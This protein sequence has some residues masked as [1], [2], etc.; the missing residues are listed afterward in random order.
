MGGHPAGA[1]SAE[2]V[3]QLCSVVSLMAQLFRG[4]PLRQAYLSIVFSGRAYYPVVLAH[5]LYSPFEPPC[6]RSFAFFPFLQKAFDKTIT[7]ATFN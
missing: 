5:C 7:G 6:S 3:G 1:G 2:G 4:K